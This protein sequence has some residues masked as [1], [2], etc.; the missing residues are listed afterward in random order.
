MTGKDRYSP[1][2]R[3]SVLMALE[4]GVA[5]VK[6]VIALAS[7]FLFTADQYGASLPAEVLH[8]S[9]I[10]ITW[11]ARMLLWALTL[12]ALS[13]LS[14]L[15]ASFGRARIWYL[16]RILILPVVFLLTLP[17]NRPHGDTT[18]LPFRLTACLYLA[19]LGAL[20]GT[21]FLSMGNRAILL[22]GAEVLDTFGVETPAKR[23]RRCGAVLLVSAAALTFSL[24]LAAVFPAGRRLIQGQPFYSTAGPKGVFSALTP[25][26][27]A[28]F[29]LCF[30]AGLGAV[31]CR[32][33]AAVRMSRTYR[34]IRELTE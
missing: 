4:T 27:A 17:A 10:Y 2:G 25:P 19:G 26:E 18:P 6:A 23:N 24:V 14:V 7:V 33:L 3:L 30:L 34:A 22:A 12:A 32:L 15:R 29:L 21:L 20:A 8:E 16:L 5:A 9:G 31:G 1:L 28:A 13:R 11:T